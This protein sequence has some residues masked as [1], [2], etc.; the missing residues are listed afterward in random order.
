MIEPSRGVELLQYLNSFISQSDTY[1]TVATILAD[2]PI[3]LLPVFLLWLYVWRGMIK[4]QVSAKYGALLIFFST[5]IA[6]IINLWLQ[7][8]IDKARPETALEW[9]WRLVMKHLPT[10]SFP[11]DHAAVSFAA[12]LAVLLW[13]MKR[14]K[15]R[16]AIWGRI[17]LI[18]SVL[19]SVARVAVGVHRP[20]DIL[21]WRVIGLLSVTIVFVHP[22]RHFFSRYIAHFIIWMEEKIFGKIRSRR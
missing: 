6:A 22:M 16:V 8:F 13:A 4:R 14:G 17:L 21:A 11:S 2:R 15:K 19:M 10:A 5:A 1:Y 20:T 7:M 9:A 3:F 12:A 18:G